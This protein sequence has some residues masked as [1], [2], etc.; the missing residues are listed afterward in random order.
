[1][2]NFLL[3][4]ITDVLRSGTLGTAA[5]QLGQSEQQVT[6]GLQMSVAS[7]GAGLA[8]KAQDKGA[9]RQL[10]DLATTRGVDPARVVSDP[11]VLTAPSTTDPATS[12]G[13]QL[14]SSVFGNNVT[15]VTSA[16]SGATGMPPQAATS[17]LGMAGSLVL[18]VLGSRIRAGGMTASGFGDWFASQRESLMR[19]APPAVRDLLGAGARPVDAAIAAGVAPGVG[20]RA[21]IP[22]V[23]AARPDR[24]LWPVIAAILVLGVVWNVLRGNR[25]AMESRAAAARPTDTATAGG[26]IA[27]VDS[28]ATAGASA[29]SAASAMIVRHLPN[30]VDLRV[31]SSG[32]EINLLGYLDDPTKHGTDTTWF[33]FDRLLFETNSATL[34]PSS[35]DQLHDVAAI[36]M[37]YPKAHVTIGGYTDNTG[38]A[39]ANLRLSQGRAGTVVD[40]LTTLGVPSDRMT[41]KGYGD[42]HPVADNGSAVGRAQN[43]RIAIRV[44]E[45]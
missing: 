3:D 36:L 10:F 39:D 27:H 13:A 16:I 5:G 42:A 37:A 30:G 22:A 12:G 40:Q 26:E 20:A 4:S 35:N 19:D 15:A 34:A 2:S 1:M 29:A 17:V 8:A 38:D 44:T 11:S 32:T 24:W 33:D 9:V 21:A 6:R 23:P 7:I 31:P 25:A 41:A 28:A 45:Q 18:G 43:R 14:L